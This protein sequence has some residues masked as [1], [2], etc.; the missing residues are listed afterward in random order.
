MVLFA[1]SEGSCKRGRFACQHVP[2][3][4]IP[5]SSYVRADRIIL[6]FFPK[7][8]QVLCSEGGRDTPF[9]R[10]YFLRRREN[11]SLHSGIFPQSPQDQLGDWGSLVGLVV[12][13]VKR[14]IANRSAAP[15][16][17]GHFIGHFGQEVSKIKLSPNMSNKRFAHGNQFTDCMVA[18]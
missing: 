11:Y 13:D 14:N 16:A 4:N 9:V 10:A 6:S 2:P 18:N 5:V 17:I 1:S 12:L 15:S 7:L 8:S 3:G